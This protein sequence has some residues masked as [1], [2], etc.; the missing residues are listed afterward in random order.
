MV[1]T[2]L[3]AIADFIRE[4][5]DFTLISHISPDGD[6]LGSALA[7][8]CIIKRMGKQAS[9]VCEDSVPQIYSF[10]PYADCVITPDAAKPGGAVI[11]I[12]CAD[13]E[14]MGGAMRIFCAAEHTANIDHH[15]TNACYADYNAVDGEA[16][17]TGELIYE[18][19]GMLLTDMDKQT[20]MCL[21]T[22]LITDTGNFAYGNTT[23]DTH[24]TAAALLQTGVDTYD[25]NRRIFRTIPYQK[26][27]LLGISIMNMQRLADGRIGIS[28]I[29]AEDMQSVG[30]S[31]EDT[32]GIID[33]I[34]DVAGVE[35]AILI[36]EC[37]EDTY[38]VSLR[39]K[40]Y[41]DV[42][43]I[44]KRMGGGGHKRAAGYTAH[45]RAEQV[46]AQTMELA[47]AALEG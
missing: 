38:K 5:C 26:K 24:R 35:I 21:Y 32:E 1:R 9:V 4:N 40:L 31:G 41:A 15:I 10:L 45:G 28:I 46:Y 37:G 11:S 34:R 20:A 2:Q 13:E 6:T 44:A 30:A 12:D 27:K 33:H 17:A 29:S 22:A 23:P 3:S 25:I 18:L 19:A 47:Q 14:R 8:L 43:A 39:S 42:S 7:L 16:A 36:R